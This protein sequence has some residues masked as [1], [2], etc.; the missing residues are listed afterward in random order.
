MTMKKLLLGSVAFVALTA[1][2]PAGAADL[3]TPVLKAAPA[4]AAA[5]FNW[6]RCYLGGHVGYGWGKNTNRFGDAIASGLTEVEGFPAEFG[7]FHHN[8]KG[9]V[10]GGQ[11][12]CNHQWA[13]NWLVGV[14]GEVWWSGIRGG[15]TAPEDFADP[16]RFSRFES[17]NRFDADL[18][19]RFGHVMGATLLYAKAG[20]A[21]GS[22]RYT[23]THD[24]FPTT[25]GCPGGAECSV[26]VS[27][28]KVGWLV[29]LGV[30]HVL[31]SPNWTVKAEWNFIDYGTHNIPYP[32]AGAG[33]P[34][35]P[36]KDTKNV[37][38]VGLNFYF[39]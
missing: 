22:F 29:G 20:V 26:S 27:Q 31:V 32:S 39:P 24:D 16:G 21:V 38:K 9:A 37:I 10:V 36:V 3:R 8:T 6:S 17:R 13:P 1:G 4:P 28:T 11:V 7:P 35:F 25:H 15:F 18:A 14:E 23:E 2:G 12:G 30:E 5:P 19:L 34:T 33:L